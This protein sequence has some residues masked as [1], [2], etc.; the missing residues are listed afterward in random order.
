MKKWVVY[1]LGV[2]TGIILSFVLSFVLA[3]I[4]GDI[5][6]SEE[7]GSNDKTMFEKPGDVIDVQEF[8][9]F[10][11]VEKNGALVTANTDYDRSFGSIYLLKNDDGKYY[12]DDEIIT[13]PEGK[14]V[15]QLGIYRYPTPN[16]MIKT[17]PIIAIMDK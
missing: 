2:L 8:K 7:L 13:I 3:S 10:Q 4:G 9:V 11:V 15:R 12:Y 1:L 6:D 16:K 14:V 5:S 17:V